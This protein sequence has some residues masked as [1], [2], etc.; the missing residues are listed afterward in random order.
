[1]GNAFVA[2]ADDEQA[3]FYNP[4]GLAGAKKISLN[5]GAVDLDVSNELVDGYS[6]LSKSLSNVGLSSINSFI[7]KQEYARATAASTLVLPGFGIAALYDQQI[8]LR[9][10]NLAFPQGQLGVQTTYGAQ[11]GFGTSLLKKRNASN[12]DLRIGVA[13]K[14]LYRAG[15]YQNLTLTQLVT[16]DTASITQ[17]LTNFGIG[18]G[19]DTGLQYV[20]PF[21]KKF[22]LMGG[23][24]LTDIGN[25]SFSTGADPIVS[26]LTLG[27]AGRY[28]TKGFR[29]TMAYD[30]AHVF[31]SADWRKK[32]HLGLELGL[33]VLS[34]YAGLN[35]VSFTYGA[36]IDLWLL[37]L[38]Y[39]SYAEEQSSAAGLN[40]ERR[41]MIHLALK[42]E[43]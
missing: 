5:L 1:M 15:G 22:T 16:L 32:S 43:I 13:A 38:M 12:G 9:L 33:P 27:V 11:I 20:R 41:M 17:N 14:M 19:V 18:Y 36:G 6:E 25:T 40:A 7:G 2:V 30:F 21:K 10:K 39:V 37:K 31:D 42:V 3:I 4:A 35:Q 8:A 28:E 24:S 23:L 34:L 26:N 29:A